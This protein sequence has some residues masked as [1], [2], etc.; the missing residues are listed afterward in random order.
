MNSTFVRGKNQDLE[1]VK[2]D[3]K[4]FGLRPGKNPNSSDKKSSK[5]GPSPQSEAAQSFLKGLE[6]KFAPSGTVLEPESK[7]GGLSKPKSAVQALDTKVCILA[8]TKIN[9]SKNMHSMTV[10]S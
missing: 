7:E 3:L 8:L 1:L 4:D 6:N 10:T 9:I 5:W 2:P